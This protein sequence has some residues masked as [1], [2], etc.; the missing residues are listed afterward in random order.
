MNTSN[1]LPQPG[2]SLP[3]DPTPNS[4]SGPDVG[5]SPLAVSEP[6]AGAESQQPALA[7]TVQA[8]TDPCGCCLAR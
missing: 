3:S 5:E 6:V 1:T 7:I 2:Q 8:P 4:I